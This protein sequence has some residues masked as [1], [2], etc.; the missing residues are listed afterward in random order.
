MLCA[1]LLEDHIN[2]APQHALAADFF[3][4]EI[5]LARVRQLYNPDPFPKQPR[6]SSNMVTHILYICLVACRRHTRARLLHNAVWVQVTGKRPLA[7]PGG[8]G[9]WQPLVPLVVLGDIG[10]PKRI[11]FSLAVLWMPSTG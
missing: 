10:T 1:V 2:S 6:P 4:R 5:V 11:G 7:F 8:Y 3:L 9:L